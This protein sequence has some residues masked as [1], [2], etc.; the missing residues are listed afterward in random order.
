MATHTSARIPRGFRSGQS[1]LNNKH[2]P[3][4]IV[5]NH[6]KHA[7]NDRNW[8]TW[9]RG[10]KR[11]SEIRIERAW[12]QRFWLASE[13]RK[14]QIYPPPPPKKMN[15]YLQEWPLNLQESFRTWWFIAQCQT[16]AQR[17]RMIPKQ[18][19][20]R[21]KEVAKLKKKTEYGVRGGG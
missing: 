4:K 3:A 7:C 21:A 20:N 15:K 17:T 8:G 11:K 5:C 12:I 2:T 19:T 9:A 10:R 13:T 6:N 16:I 18:S 14:L 1:P